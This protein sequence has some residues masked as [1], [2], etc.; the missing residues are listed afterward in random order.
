MEKL[1][2]KL[3]EALMKPPRYRYTSEDLRDSF[4]CFPNNRFATRLDFELMTPLGHKFGV[5]VYFPC[6]E[7]GEVSLLNEFV[8]YCHSHSGS[9]TEG[10][11]LLNH[12]AQLGV[13]LVV[14][15][16]QANGYSTGEYCTLGYYESLALNEVVKFMKTEA[17]A[18]RLAIWGRSMGAAASIFFM[19]VKFRHAMRAKHPDVRWAPKS[20][21]DCLVLDS[22]FLSLKRAISNLIKHRASAVPDV[23]IELAT[24]ALNS[25]MM[26]R[27]KLDIRE[28]NPFEYCNEI[29]LPTFFFV[30]DDDEFVNLVDF[31]EMNER[32]PAKVKNFQIYHNLTHNG[33]RGKQLISQGAFFVRYFFDRRT[34]LHKTIMVKDSAVRSVQSARDRV[35]PSTSTAKASML[36]IQLVMPQT[37]FISSPHQELS[38]PPD[39]LTDIRDNYE[40][41]QEKKYYADLLK[42]QKVADDLRTGQPQVE[43]PQTPFTEVFFDF[44]KEVQ[45]AEPAKDFTVIKTIPS[46]TYDSQLN[47]FAGLTLPS[48]IRNERSS[49]ALRATSYSTISQS[50]QKP[51]V[52]DSRLIKNGQETQKHDPLPNNSYLNLDIYKKATQ[53]QKVVHESQ[54][55]VDKSK[56]SEKEFNGPILRHV[57]I[58][59]D[60]SKEIPITAT[61]Q[62]NAFG[63]SQYGF[64][65]SNAQR[66]TPQP[67]SFLKNL[68]RNYTQELP[69]HVSF[70]LGTRTTPQIYPSSFYE[71]RNSLGFSRIS[72]NFQNRKS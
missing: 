51:S 66:E 4:V 50:A 26:A 53:V 24:D 60:H 1:R 67:S 17:K 12:L 20:W 71:P 29:R 41:P 32:I 61:Q 72:A 59:S 25:E 36:N 70:N 34:E 42:R 65:P 38:Q 19:S 46:S 58:P 33:D 35:R 62:V 56:P 9:R 57:F 37:G 49:P 47:F 22:S 31:L 15:D 6:N 44:F 7:Q 8:I 52:L 3:W 14:F 11:I 40:V 10:L 30:G 45:K 43:Q 28:I 39:P 27:V 5:S 18:F 69:R 21:I 55:F 2:A 64:A 13:G 23:A 48:V 63:N 16:F 54:F 68:S